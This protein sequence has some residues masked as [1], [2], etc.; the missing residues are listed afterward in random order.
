[1]QRGSWRPAVLLSTPYM[2]GVFQTMLLVFHYHEIIRELSGAC[3]NT[4]VINRL[5]ESRLVMAIPL[6]PK[7]LIFTNTSWHRVLPFVTCNSTSRFTLRGV[8]WFLKSGLHHALLE[9]QNR[10][11]EKALGW[12]FTLGKFKHHHGG[13]E[14]RNKNS[15]QGKLGHEFCSD[16][17]LGSESPCYWSCKQKE[18]SI[19][20]VPQSMPS[21]KE[22][23]RGS[24]R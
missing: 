3:W 2:P 20:E 13:I 21:Q 19:A 24:G 14:S 9:V 5:S 15:F 8:Q 6:D 10:F 17:E 1:M 22:T 7:N 11:Q 16:V 12:D 4:I 18:V 23:A